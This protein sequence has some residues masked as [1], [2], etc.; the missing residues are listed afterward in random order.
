MSWVFFYGDWMCISVER[1]K[2][3]REN[4]G[5]EFTPAGSLIYFIYDYM[6]CRL[7]VHQ[8]TD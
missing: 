6:D 8:K 2:T 4:K 3:V 7:L 5:R 1:L